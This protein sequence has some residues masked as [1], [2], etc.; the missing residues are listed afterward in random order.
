MKYMLVAPTEVI[1]EWLYFKLLYYGLVMTFMKLWSDIQGM[2][3]NTHLWS[4]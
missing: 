4:L 2:A 3:L 1:K